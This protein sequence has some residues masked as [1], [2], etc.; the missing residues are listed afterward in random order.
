MRRNLGVA[1]T[2]NGQQGKQIFD[3]EW[4]GRARRDSNSRPT[5]PEAVPTAKA[6]TKS[7]SYP[8]STSVLRGINGAN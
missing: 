2:R 1:H 4:N 5:A 7:P 6:I 8:R 3:R